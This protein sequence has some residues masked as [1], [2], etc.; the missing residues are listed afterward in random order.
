LYEKEA[1]S[2]LEELENSTSVFEELENSASVFEELEIISDGRWEELEI[3]SA[4]E[5]S[6]LLAI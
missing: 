3:S 1:S 5:L 4:E 6:A 2:L